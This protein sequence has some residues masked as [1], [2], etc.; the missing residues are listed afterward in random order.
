MKLSLNLVSRSLAATLAAAALAAP[1]GAQVQD[2]RSPD[3][4]DAA[5]LQRPVDVRDA[6]G[7]S[8]VAWQS[9][10]MAVQTPA[11]AQA[12]DDAFD[13]RSAAIGAAVAAALAFTLFAYRT[14]PRVAR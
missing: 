2:L 5:T 6:P 9:R 7:Y 1:A 11:P 14:R 8:A 3:T 12:T 4:K 13:W 10:E